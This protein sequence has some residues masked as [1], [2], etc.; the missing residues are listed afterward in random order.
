M[1]MK[2]LIKSIPI[3]AKKGQIHAL[4]TGVLMA[5]AVTCIAF[6]GCAI[7]LTYTGL[8]ESTVPLIV[9]ITCVISVFIAGFDASR[10]SE[11]NG[12]LW[13]IIAGAVYALILFC[14][15]AWLSRGFAIDSRKVT[16][17]VLSL[18]SGGTGGVLGIN[19][20]K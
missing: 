19:F 5:Y 3:T 7:A 8:S 12:W 20:K 10:V 18:A 1:K 13:G 9:A 16:L 17:L 14:I 4:M 15:L 11:K 6:I 2:T